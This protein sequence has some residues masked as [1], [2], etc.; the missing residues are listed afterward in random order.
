MCACTSH[1]ARRIQS[2]MDSETR[3]S[4]GGRSTFSGRNQTGGIRS[5]TK[6]R[7][8]GEENA[9]TIDV[10]WKSATRQSLLKRIYALPRPTRVCETVEI[11][12]AISSF[13]TTCSE[14]DS[15]QAIAHGTLT[16]HC[17]KWVLINSFL[18]FLECVPMCWILLH[19][20]WVHA[21]ELKWG[22]THTFLFYEL[23]LHT[24]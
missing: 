19:L 4:T 5:S 20:C 16:K 17:L 8:R 15:V 3:N 6:G 18:L 21:H 1:V 2:S 7:R 12:A 9:C 23:H 10:H 22:N 13:G 11:R 14:T 24:G